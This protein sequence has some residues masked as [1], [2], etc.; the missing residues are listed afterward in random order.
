MSRL[1]RRALLPALALFA[2]G[3]SASAEVRGGR[4]ASKALGREVA[5]A[6]QLPPSYAA[7]T[8]TYPVVY[9][10]H[11]LF[12]SH[13]FWERRGLAEEVDR[14][15]ASHAVP[16]VVIVAVD[17]DNSFFAN[18]PV[19]AYED[20]VTRD[21]VDHVEATYR[22]TRGRGGRAL[23]GISMGGYAALRM[24]F[25]HPEAFAAVATHSA[26]LLREPPRP[27]SGADAWQLAAFARVFGDPID[28]PRWTADDP[29]TWAR[30][31]AP[32]DVP[33]VYLDCGEQDRYGLAAGHRALDRLLT[34]RGIGHSFALRPGD[35]GYEFVRAALPLSLQFLSEHMAGR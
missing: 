2:A 26:M 28:G 35:H 7:G 15:W 22:V 3:S 14:L 32:K 33:A 1:L 21:L 4:F 16:E 8:R 13:L 17:G 9:V 30:T 23:L 29:F 34:E 31:V 10:L 6:V 11:G 20:L 19:G 12:E 27:G 25:E 5:Y 18:S 24:A